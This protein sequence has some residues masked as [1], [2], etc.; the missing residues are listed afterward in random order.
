MLRRL[1]ILAALALPLAVPAAAPAGIATKAGGVITWTDSAGVP[2]DVEV[3]AG[4]G[5]VV[6]FVFEEGEPI[7]A[8]TPRPARAART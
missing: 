8:A 3:F 6:F 1:A 4:G 7:P 5:E 2:D